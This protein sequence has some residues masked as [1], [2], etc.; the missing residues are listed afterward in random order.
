MDR[1][2]CDFLQQQ[3]WAVVGA[4]ANPEKFGYKIYKLLK[5]YG[6]TVYPVNPRE[7]EIEGQPCY[8]SLAELPAVPGAVD[9]VVPAAA[10]VEVARQCDRLGI[11]KVWFQ[12]GVADDAVIAEA[13]ALGL[14]FIHHNCVM[15]QSSKI[16]MQGRKVWAVAAGDD[17]GRALAGALTAKGH[18]VYIVAAAPGSGEF[19]SLQ[20]L[21]VPP[22]AVA[23]AAP[24]AFAGRIIA[25]CAG[26]GV[27]GVWL[28]QGFETDA[29]IH[30]AVAARMT[31]VHHA[32]L[33]EEYAAIAGCRPG[34]PI[35]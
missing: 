30:Q 22:E 3:V 1:Q 32:A 34:T 28:E 27:P 14:N 35:P 25:E 18:S 12:P 15:V 7:A 13:Q 31:V 23:I 2:I 16:Y 29:L 6:Y 17:K 20:D 10:A 9:V 21:P 4:S 24:E 19:S 26:L 11:K 33:A 5:R 8:A